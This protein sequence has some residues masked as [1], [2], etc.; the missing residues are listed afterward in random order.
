MK[1]IFISLIVTIL[2][3]QAVQQYSESSCILLKQQVVDY[4]RRLGVNSSLYAKTKSNFDTNCQNPIAV[5]SSK[6]VSLTNKQVQPLAKA[7]PIEVE[8]IPLRKVSSTNTQLQSAQPNPFSQTTNTLMLMLMFFFFGLMA[9]YYFKKKIPVIK[10]RIG[11]K[12]A[13]K[14][15][16]QH[17]DETQYSIVN[18]VTLPL[19]D[20]G[21]TQIDHVVVSRFGIFVI[22]TKNMSGWIFGNENQAKW[23][24]T[25]YRS[26]Y[27]FQNPL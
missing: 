10:G 7:V 15:L 12:H 2:P 8:P 16:K 21:T 14:G 1:W 22:E 11:E 5:K 27:P 9:I 26:K 17:L 6:I 4:K 18:D 19:E 24:Q 25:I 3:V 20:G 23:T 13:I